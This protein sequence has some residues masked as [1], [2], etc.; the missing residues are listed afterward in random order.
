MDQLLTQWLETEPALGDERVRSA[1]R[2]SLKTW[3]TL[4]PPICIEVAG[5]VEDLQEGMSSSWKERYRA[6]LDGMEREWDTM[7]QAVSDKHVTV[8]ERNN[9][10]VGYVFCGAQNDDKM[11]IKWIVCGTEKF[12]ED[13]QNVQKQHEQDSFN[14]KYKRTE[15]HTP[16]R[17]VDALDDQYKEHRYQ[18]VCKFSVPKHDSGWVKI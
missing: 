17:D 8:Y 9:K 18:R 12:T 6:E 3:K 1:V 14:K 10:R 4:P 15:A 13:F 5:G 2:T 11:T 7:R 16:Y